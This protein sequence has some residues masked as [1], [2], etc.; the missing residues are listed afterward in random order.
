MWALIDYNDTVLNVYPPD[1][2]QKQMTKEADGRR[3]ILMTIEN[4][5]GWIH[6]TYKDNKFYPPDKNFDNGGK[7]EN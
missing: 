5:P 2:D 1:Y 4:S 7:G 3:L 6:G